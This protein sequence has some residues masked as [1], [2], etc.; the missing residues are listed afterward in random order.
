MVAS[1][2]VADTASWAR[3]APGGKL[4]ASQPRHGACSQKAPPASLQLCRG[5]SLGEPRGSGEP[6]RGVRLLQRR[7]LVPRVQCN[8][9][10]ASPGESRLGRARADTGRPFSGTRPATPDL[11]SWVH[12]SRACDFEVW[13][14]RAR[15]GEPRKREWGHREEINEEETA[16]LL[17]KTKTARKKGGG[18]EGGKDF[19]KSSEKLEHMTGNDAMPGGMLA[20]IFS[21]C[22]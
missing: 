16:S 8:A 11:L 20:L 7:R 6:G 1:S 21:L 15:V 13:V 18:R 3:T 9:V 5:V 17:P 14:Q 19:T 22:T 4:A 12:G 10:P 2:R